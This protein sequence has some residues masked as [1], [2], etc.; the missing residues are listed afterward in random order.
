[1]LKG[2][3]HI[4]STFSDSNKTIKEIITIATNKKLDAIAITDH[5][6]LSHLNEIPKTDKIKVIGGIEISAI[7]KLTNNKAHILG[8]NIK[9]PEIVKNLVTPLLYARHENSLK[10]IEI[11]NRNGLNIDID[12]L[13]KAEGKYIYKQHIMEYLVYTKQANEMFGDFYNKTF[14]NGGICDFDIE[15]INVFEAIRLIYEA[16][17]Q[18]VLAHPGQQ[19]NFCLVPALKSLGLFGLEY[20]HFTNNKNDKI[21]LKELSEKYGLYLTGGSDY[22]GKYESVNVD[23]GDY[24]SEESGVKEI[25]YV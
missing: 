15:Y 18:A 13:N 19:K 24:I 14:K 6:T 25:C 22:H 16:G 5:D 23:I 7:D 11:M 21:I 10:Q 3:L 9:K 1:M 17:G 20:N 2:D 12:K 8:Y 4:H